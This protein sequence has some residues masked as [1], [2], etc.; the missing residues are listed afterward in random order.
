MFLDYV[1]VFFVLYFL[2]D[3]ASENLPAYR[4]SWCLSLIIST[5]LSYEA[6]YALASWDTSDT[7]KQAFSSNP[8]ADRATDIFL[9]F[10]LCDLVCGA[11]SYPN[12][13]RIL[14]GIIHHV[15]YSCLLLFLK[16]QDWTCLF[17]LCT[18]CE[19]PTVVMA[20]G[21]LFA[22]KSYA[23]LVLQALTFWCFRIFL[24]G[25][26]A[27]CF[28]SSLDPIHFWWTVPIFSAIFSAHL[29]W[30]VQLVKKL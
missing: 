3:V 25:A 19:I 5:L 6:A 23:F 20:C 17:W 24:Y 16:S 28:F 22:L 1:G 2:F 18:F 27:V 21:K 29:H 30:G 10:C 13:V 15:L 8:R 7:A 26:F 14:E 11:I 12:E 9:A 4:K